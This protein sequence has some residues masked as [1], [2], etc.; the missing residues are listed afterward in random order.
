MN[1]E[2]ELEKLRQLAIALKVN[3]EILEHATKVNHVPNAYATSQAMLYALKE[4]DKIAHKRYN[5]WNAGE[6]F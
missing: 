5:E 2:Q 1:K 4:F 3:M 6:D